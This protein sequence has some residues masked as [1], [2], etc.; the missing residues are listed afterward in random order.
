LEHLG[1]VGAHVDAVPHVPLQTAK[2][3]W[4]II[5][6]GHLTCVELKGL[7]PEALLQFEGVLLVVLPLA[8]FA[9]LEGMSQE[10]KVDLGVGKD[11]ELLAASWV[12]NCLAEEVVLEWQSC[13]RGLDESLRFDIVD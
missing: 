11:T 2:H 3:N 8:P 1:F 6:V 13:L 10:V 5:R 12:E 4:R 9:L 7:E